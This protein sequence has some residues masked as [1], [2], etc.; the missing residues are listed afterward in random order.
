[1]INCWCVWCPSFARAN[2]CFMLIG[3]KKVPSKIPN[4][5]RSCMTC[6]KWQTDRCWRVVECWG[7]RGGCWMI[8]G[9]RLTPHE[10]LLAR[11][12]KIVVGRLPSWELSLPMWGGGKPAGASHLASSCPRC[13][14]E[15]HRGLCWCHLSRWK[16]CTISLLDTWIIRG[17]W[18]GE[19]CQKRPG[20][21]GNVESGRLCRLKHRC[22]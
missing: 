17:F 4:D 13:C 2:C 19:R 10:Q 14:E 15:L 3:W 22:Q 12:W 21:C 11:P 18:G 5:G 6:W 8:L 20:G 16:P 9:I 1:M 7:T